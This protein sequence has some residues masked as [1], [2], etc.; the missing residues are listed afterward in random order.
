MVSERP[1]HEETR[2]GGKR[3]ASFGF[4]YRLRRKFY[5][6][7]T[8][9]VSVQRHHVARKQNGVF[10]QF[11]VQHYAVAAYGPKSVWVIGFGR[12]ETTFC[13]HTQGR[14]RPRT[15]FQERNVYIVEGTDP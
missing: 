15:L 1:G 7:A 12:F 5:R 11:H 14:L 4:L 8:K 13:L 10:L 2:N 6:D 9:H 3:I